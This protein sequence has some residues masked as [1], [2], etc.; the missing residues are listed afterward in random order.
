[1]DIKG[2]TIGFALTGSFCT[3][4]KV[5]PEVANLVKEGVKVIPIM[6]E[7]AYSIDTRFGK[8]QDF[9]Q[10]LE[11]ITGN[12]V[13][14]S[15][16]AAEPIGP[17]ALLDALIIAPCT[18]NTLSKLANAVTDTSVTMAAKAHLRNLRPVIIAVSTNDGLGA[19]AK[20]IGLLLNTKNIY[21]VP[22]QQ[23][24]PVH[25]YNSLIAKMSLIIPTLKKALDGEQIQPII[26]G[27]DE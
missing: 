24:D 21:L 19:N 25:K 17:K 5:I 13:I 16:S 23:D 27:T 11:E 4:T 12:Q 9:V 10:Q 18:G 22:F 20:N 3:F 1:M 6:S 14:S 8:A 15:I 26:L 2:L 7:N